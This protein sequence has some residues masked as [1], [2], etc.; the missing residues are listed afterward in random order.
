MKRGRFG[1]FFS[2]KPII[3]HIYSIS[4]FHNEHSRALWNRRAPLWSFALGISS[5]TRPAH[6]NHLANLYRNHVSKSTI[7]SEDFKTTEMK[8]VLVFGGKTGWIG[9]MMV[10][11]V[12]E[13]TYCGTCKSCGCSNEVGECFQVL[14]IG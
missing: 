11:L 12:K 13:G 1:V 10:E 5:Q 3:M 6:F 8:R 4:I 14:C 2:R 9:Q 7:M